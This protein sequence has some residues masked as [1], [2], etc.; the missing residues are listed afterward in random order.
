MTIQEPAVDGALQPA[1]QALQD[2]ISDLIDPRPEPSDQGT[3]WLD[4][5][6]H[7]L[8]DALTSQRIGSRSKPQSQPPA[9]LDAID[10]LK[11]IDQRARELEPSWPISECDEYPTIQRLRQLDARKWRPQDV[12]EIDTIT[13]DLNK[14]A[15]DI[16]KLFS[17][18]PKYLPDPCPRCRNTHARRL[19]DEGK[20][21]RIPALAI[22]DDGCT[23][24]VC[25]EYWPPERLMFLGRVLGYRIEGVIEH[26]ESHTGNSGENVL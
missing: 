25:K 21:T 12:Q 13:G 19:D 17:N 16:D 3:Q 23:C 5:R 10:L 7:D 14:Y 22:T 4:S 1:R 18:P 24:N 9:W 6:Y 26:P 15:V 2:A 11:T 20:P 8:R